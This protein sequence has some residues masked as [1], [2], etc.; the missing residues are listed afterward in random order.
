[1]TELTDLLG[2]LRSRMREDLDVASRGHEVVSAKF[3]RWCLDE[4]DHL[5]R[6][7]DSGHRPTHEVDTYLRRMAV[8]YD[9]HPDFR[10]EW[11]RP[12]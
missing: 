11:R 4:L 6:D 2:F 1:M 7:A 10:P 3:I 5:E 9:D 12:G 8:A